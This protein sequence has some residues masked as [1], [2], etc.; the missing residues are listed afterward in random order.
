MTSM[1]NVQFSRLPTLFSIYVQNSST[2]LTALTL[3][4]Q[5]QTTLPS[6]SNNVHVNERNQNKNKIK[7]GHI[8][9]DHAFC[10]S[11]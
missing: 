9:I 7:A 3:D 5:F 8:Q 11:I 4:V 1:K 10:S 6:P 2:L